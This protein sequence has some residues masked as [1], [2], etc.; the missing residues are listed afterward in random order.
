MALINFQKQFAE[1]VKSG[2]KKQT[3]RAP[4]KYSIKSGEILHLYTGLRTKKCKKLQKV[5][6]KSVQDV[7][8]NNIGMLTIDGIS[9]IDSCL[10]ANIYYFD[11][12]DVFA[13]ADGFKD[14]KDMIKWFSETHG[15]PFKGWLIKW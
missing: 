4:R 7:T 14:W 10:K 3:I 2:K 11:Y 5:V 12:L 13:Q 8:I 9:I 1:A 6:C 15:L